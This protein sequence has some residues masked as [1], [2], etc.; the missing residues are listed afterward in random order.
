MGGGQGG[1]GGGGGGGGLG[2]VKKRKS[3]KVWSLKVNKLKNKVRVN[4]L[5][6]LTLVSKVIPELQSKFCCVVYFLNIILYSFIIIVILQICI[7]IICYTLYFTCVK[8]GCTGHAWHL[9]HGL[10]V[11]QTLE[12]VSN[13]VLLSF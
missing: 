3:R 9:L 5:C 12:V 8:F 2:G 13:L 1:G 7:I 11:D 4:E 10:H 6:R